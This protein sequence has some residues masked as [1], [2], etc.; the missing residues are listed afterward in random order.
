MGVSV[1][2]HRGQYPVCSVDLLKW[3]G[4]CGHCLAGALTQRKALKTHLSHLGGGG[5]RAVSNVNNPFWTSPC[6][7]VRV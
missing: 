6:S 7:F 1:Q 5:G 2:S 4:S 3:V